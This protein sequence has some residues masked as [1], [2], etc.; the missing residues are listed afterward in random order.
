MIRK[1]VV[2]GSLGGGAAGSLLA[3]GIRLALATGWAWLWPHL[4]VPWDV[5]NDVF[6]YLWPD[7]DLCF[8][9]LFLIFVAVYIWG[10]S[11]IL[12]WLENPEDEK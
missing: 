12:D 3:F 8:T 4:D 5:G 10:A 1:W 7:G 6:W 9:G 11:R 2:Y